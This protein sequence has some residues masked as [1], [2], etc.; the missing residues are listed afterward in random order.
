[1]LSLSVDITSLITDLRN[2]KRQYSFIPYVSNNLTCPICGKSGSLT[3][4]VTVSKKKYRYKRWYVYHE[5]PAYPNRKQKWCYLNKKHLEEPKLK[6]KINKLRAYSKL[7]APLLTEIEK[8]KIITCPLCKTKVRIDRVGGYG[9]KV[10]LECSRII[11][12]IYLDH[13]RD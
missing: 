10:V 5:I 4:K 13:H 1:M 3:K 9:D 8:A 7:V 6:E 2:L 12:H 11:H